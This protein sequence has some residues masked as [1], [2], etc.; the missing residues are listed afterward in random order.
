MKLILLAVLFIGASAQAETQIV[1]CSVGHVDKSGQAR[2]LIPQKDLVLDLGSADDRKSS[3]LIGTVYGTTFTVSSPFTIAVPVL[4]I[5]A[6]YSAQTVSTL[7]EL[8]AEQENI[9][10]LSFQNPATGTLTASCSMDLRK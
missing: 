8:N 4:V 6:V 7:R 1:N 9:L 5:K 10:I 3:Q 2:D